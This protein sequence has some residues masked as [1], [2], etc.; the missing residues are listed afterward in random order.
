MVDNE[1]EDKVLTGESGSFN[2]EF[3]ES[4]NS[5]VLDEREENGKGES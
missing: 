1:E 5:G 3:R 4:K 2:Y